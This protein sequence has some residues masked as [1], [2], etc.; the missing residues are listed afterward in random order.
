MFQRGILSP[1]MSILWNFFFHYLYK[2]AIE[3]GF[4]KNM[5]QSS[6]AIQIN[7]S[8]NN[9]FLWRIFIWWPFLLFAL[10]HNWNCSQSPQLHYASLIFKIF[11]AVSM[12]SFLKTGNFCWWLDNG[13]GPR[14]SAVIRKLWVQWR[15]SNLLTSFLS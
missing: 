13:H 7:N 3:A 15:R 4:Q 10:P 12:R 11:A 6:E 5:S 9:R 8:K 2:K 1:I 14:I